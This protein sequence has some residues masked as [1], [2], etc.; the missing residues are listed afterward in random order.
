MKPRP[1]QDRDISRI[2]D[3][4]SRVKRVVYVACCGSGKTHVFT[5]IAKGVIRR[6]KSAVIM[7]HRKELIMQCS[8]KLRGLG[9]PHGIIKAGIDPEYHLPVQVASTQT[10]VKRTEHINPDLL[11]GDEG[12]HAQARTVQALIKNFPEAYLLLVTAT[13]VGLNKNHVDEMIVGPTVKEM[14]EDGYL[15]ETHVY[16]PPVIADL[17]RVDYNNEDDLERE[18]NKRRVTGDAVDHYARIAPGMSAIVTCVNVKHAHAVA[19]QFRESGWDFRAIDGTM[20]DSVRDRL[21]ED[22]RAGLFH[23]LCQ[24]DIVG[25]GTDVPN[26]RVMIK[27]RPTNSHIVNVQNDGRVNRTDYA[28]GMPLDTREQRKAAIAA[29]SKPFAVVIDHVANYRFHGWPDDEFDYSLDAAPKSRCTEAAFYVSQCQ[30]CYRAFRGV[31]CPS[32]QTVREIKDRKILY[33]EG[34]L[35]RIKKEDAAAAKVAEE[36]LKKQ[37]EI[38]RRAAK[39][40]PELTAF[41]VKYQYENPEAWARNWQQ[42]RNKHRGR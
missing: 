3:S 25:E 30:N 39:T 32:C 42:L 31:A 7:A 27:L 2:R 21:M 24:C 35:E 40:L 22:F 20:D 29:S 18:M 5:T 36:R 28:A 6:N 38:D 37:K 16:A 41:A 12:H 8:D 1:Y 4:F 33:T 11:V 9:V 13:P 26:C 14:V 10:L 15:V 19:A 23:G 17:S 34:Q